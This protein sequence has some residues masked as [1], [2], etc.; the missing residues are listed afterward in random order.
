[1][2]R[3]LLSLASALTLGSIVS[4]TSAAVVGQALS[5]RNAED[6]LDRRFVCLE[7]TYYEVFA[8]V[9]MSNVS[10][11]A[12]NDIDD[13]CRYWIDLP[14]AT[15]YFRTVTPTTFVAPPPIR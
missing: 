4:I 3:S 2:H 1:M 15:S 9:G 6:E 7:D 12:E 11:A 13:F 14:Y 5:P 8:S 10:D